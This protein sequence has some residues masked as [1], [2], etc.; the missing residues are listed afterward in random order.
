M[1]EIL[2]GILIYLLLLISVLLTS[3]TVWALHL[4]IESMRKRDD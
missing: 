4:I 1:N 2:G 3:G